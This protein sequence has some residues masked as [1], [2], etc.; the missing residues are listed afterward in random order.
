MSDTRGLVIVGDSSFAEVAHEYLTEDS[1]YQVAAFAVE[2]AHLTRGTLL[3]LPVV[4]LEDLAQAFPPDGHEVYVAVVYG[5]LN[6]LRTRLVETVDAMGYNLAS[7]VSSHARVSPSAKMGRHCFIFEDNVIQPYVNIGDNVVFWSGNHIGHHST[8][9]DNCFISSHVVVSGHCE[10]GDNC[11][12][13]VNSATADNVRI[14]KDCWIGPGVTIT[15]NTVAGNLFP[16][17]KVEAAR[18]STYR[19]FKIDPEPCAGASED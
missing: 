1:D 3:G 18:A 6:R 16:A 7:Y 15:A 14:A 8:I 17:A 5:E 2:R 10:I 9:G 11:F 13:G 4:A 19:F 12:F